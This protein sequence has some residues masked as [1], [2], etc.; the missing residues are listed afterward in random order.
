MGPCRCRSRG[1]PVTTRSPGSLVGGSPGPRRR[2]ASGASPQ[3]ARPE[4]R[5]SCSGRTGAVVGVA[6]V[7]EVSLPDGVERE[8]V[9]LPLVGFGLGDG[10]R[11]A[12]TQTVV[13]LA[14]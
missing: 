7:G 5:T 1:W 3:A 10:L 13:T 14:G 6:G 12:A 2:T 4:A 8:V 9:E 11:V